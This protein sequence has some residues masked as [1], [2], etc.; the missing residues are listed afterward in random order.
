M[1]THFCL[2]RLIW[3]AILSVSPQYYYK[4]VGQIN[5][6]AGFKI[7]SYTVLNLRRLGSIWVSPDGLADTVTVAAAVLFLMQLMRE[8]VSTAF[9]TSPTK[10][11]SPTR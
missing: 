3:G 5:V 7:S 1:Q 10:T 11:G 8:P 2:W 6:K 4:I 9:F